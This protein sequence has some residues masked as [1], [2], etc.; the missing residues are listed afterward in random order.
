MSLRQNTFNS[1]IDENAKLKRHIASLERDLKF[2][3]SLLWPEQSRVY[4]AAM[5]W[6]KERLG[7]NY[8]PSAVGRLYAA[9]ER[10]GK[11]RANRSVILDAQRLNSGVRRSFIA[12]RPLE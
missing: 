10:A 5:Q 6:H 4:R 3:K 8:A 11:K 1:L 7:A 2:T 9:C 12:A